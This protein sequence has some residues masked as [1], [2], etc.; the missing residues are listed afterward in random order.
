MLRRLALVPLLALAACASDPPP[1]LA[2]RAAPSNAAVAEPSRALPPAAHE[3]EPGVAL[4]ELFTSEGC[5]S[6]P[7]ADDALARLVAEGHPGVIALAYHVDYWDHLGWRDP[8]GSAAHSARQRRY[9]PTLD[10]RVY[11]PQAVVNGTTGVVGSRER[12]LREIVG[13]ALAS[14]QEVPLAVRVR[15]EGG[16]VT[17]TPE[18]AGAVPEGAVVRAALVQR[19]A[20]TDVAR[21]ENGGRRLEHVHVVRD[22]AA[23]AAGP[24]A[25]A[26]PPEAA[27][28]EAG[29][30]FVAAWVQ[31]G[32]T[33]PVLGATTAEI[34]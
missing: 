3:A 34:E 13:R 33:G 25:L 11:T 21:G 17:V 9:A 24:L 16:A 12:A 31:E 29:G 28:L 4:V 5:S 22:L 1:P 15:R 14:P 30:L 10:R 8:Y 6:C 23:G 18:A 7:P 26:V 2:E 19:E 32:E 27:G 20:A